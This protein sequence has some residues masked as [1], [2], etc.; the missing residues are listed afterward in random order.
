[1]VY[2]DTNCVIYLVEQNPTWLPKVTVRIARLRAAHDQLVI[3]DLTRAECL[4]GP[5]LIHT[6]DETV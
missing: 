6:L 3:G 2:L 5:F 4:V 1:M